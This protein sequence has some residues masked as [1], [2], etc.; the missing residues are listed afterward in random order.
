M[1]R[2]AIVDD[3]AWARTRLQRLLK[4]VAPT[5]IHVAATCVDVD[6]LLE[7][8][9]ELK[10]DVL[11]LDI[12][13]PGT[14][15]FTALS[16]WQGPLPLIVFVTAFEDYAVK[17]FDA[18]AVDYLLK[19]INAERL[20]E[21]VARIMQMASVRSE[22]DAGA[23]QGRRVPLSAGKHT[24]FVLEHQIHSIEADRNYIEVHTQSG[25]FMLRRTLNS[26]LAEL[27]SDAF[28]RVHRSVA[29]RRDAVRKLMPLGSGRY[30]LE[31][32]DGRT[33]I[34]G[35][36]YRDDVRTLLDGSADQGHT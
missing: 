12:V 31:L 17:A 16:R 11:F 6:D 22:S 10:V 7:K 30:Q 9:A 33:I 35:R 18:R 5:Q 24:H 26:F 32:I 15:G 27:S 3:E 20:R 23:I 25:R 36:N 21:A 4:M 13:M 29:V 2:A 8:V 34:S 1:L 14:D 19:P 28:C